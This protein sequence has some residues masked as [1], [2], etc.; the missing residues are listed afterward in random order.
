MVLL[1]VMAQHPQI[2]ILVAEVVLVLLEQLG[3]VLL[4]QVEQEKIIVQYL[5]QQ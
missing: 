3:I 4:E 2:T 5:E 1:E